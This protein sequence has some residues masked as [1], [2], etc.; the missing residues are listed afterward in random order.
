MDDQ[1]PLL[2]VDDDPTNRELMV[3]RLRRRGYAVEAAAS[4][5]ECLA[6]LALAPVA[7]VLLDV[8]MPDMSGFEVLGAMRSGSGAAAPRVP[9]LMVTAKDQSEDVVTALELGADD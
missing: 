1:L 9:V 4:G 2:V 5:A 8:Q 3:R 6:R 7:M